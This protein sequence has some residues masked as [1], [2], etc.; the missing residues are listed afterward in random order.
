MSWSMDLNTPRRQ[1]SYGRRTLQSVNRLKNL[2]GA[3]QPFSAIADPRTAVVVVIPGHVWIIVPQQRRT[4]V[5]ARDPLAENLEHLQMRPD[6]E[7]LRRAALG[8]QSDLRVRSRCGAEHPGQFGNRHVGIYLDSFDPVFIAVEPGCHV[9]GAQGFPRRQLRSDPVPKS[10]IGQSRI[11]RRAIKRFGDRGPGHGST[12][13]EPTFITV[14]T[15]N[16]T[17]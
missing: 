9:D 5:G 12:P 1:K 7:P 3:F 15:G 11:A 14:R 4:R 2:P 8:V 17:G 16:V 13:S 10:P 6:P